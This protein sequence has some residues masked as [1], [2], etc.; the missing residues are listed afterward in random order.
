MDHGN[1]DHGAVAHG[2]GHC[3]L[4]HSGHGGH[5]M[6][7]AVML[8]FSHG[9]HGHGIHLSHVG[10][11]SSFAHGHAAQASAVGRQGDPKAQK[12]AFEEAVAGN[13]EHNSFIVNVSLH[14]NVD[15][16]SVFAAIAP[17]LDLVRIDSLRPGLDNIDNLKF[18]ISDWDTWDP[19]SNT[20]DK[21]GGNFPGA[22]GTTAFRRQFWQVG[23]RKGLSRK[24]QFDPH[25]STYLEVSWLVWRFEQTADFDTRFDVRVLTVP[26]WDERDGAWGVKK[27][28]LIA[29]RK[30][31]IAL[32]EH[33][34]DVLTQTPPSEA[35][36]LLRA[37]VNQLHPGHEGD[38]AT[39]SIRVATSDEEHALEMERL[40][41]DKGQDEWTLAQTGKT[42]GAD[43]GSGA[44]G[45]AEGILGPV[46]TNRISF[47]VPDED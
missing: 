12:K 24:V 28:P 32:C 1:S 2:L 27:E 3:G 11:H 18:E 31:A 37:R 38:D 42:A 19:R 39:Q 22:R 5:V 21:P 30:A 25:A 8:S 43:A 14:G 16:A 23:K 4:G 26:V 36:K 46:D 7:E 9:A 45:D 13:L 15:M 20:G 33:V 17:K 47:N 44:G 41:R 40:G 29:H 34:F 6:H 10:A 35:S